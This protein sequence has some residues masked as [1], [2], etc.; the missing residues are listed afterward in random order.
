[1]GATAEIKGVLLA[2]SLKYFDT[3]FFDI[4]PEDSRS[5][6][7]VTKLGAIFS[8]IASDDKAVYALAKST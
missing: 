1:M 4:V 5:I 6:A 3:V 8:H 2:L 7:A